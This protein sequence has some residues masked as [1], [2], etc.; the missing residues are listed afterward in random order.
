MD[1][2]EI[3][4][5]LADSSTICLCS[6]P[7]CQKCCYLRIQ[8]DVAKEM[9]SEGYAGEVGVVACA[10]EAMRRFRSKGVEGGADKVG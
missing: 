7:N 6:N 10:K 1:D 5:V 4:E 2:R 9:L 8:S 3:L